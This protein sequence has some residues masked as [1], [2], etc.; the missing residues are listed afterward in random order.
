MSFSLI[1]KKK[2]HTIIFADSFF[3]MK[4]AGSALLRKT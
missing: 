3:G 2:I 4:Q 1:K